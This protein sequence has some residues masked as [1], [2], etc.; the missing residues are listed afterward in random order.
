MAASPLKIRWTAMAARDLKSVHE[1]VSEESPTQADALIDR[2]LSSIEVLER[3]PDLGRKGRV[4][5]TREL[6]IARTPFIVFYRL[7]RD[8][9]EI[10]SVLHAARK[11]PDNL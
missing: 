1:Y 2:I 7:R 3:F 4:Q 8:Q 5:G 6:V 10:L 9:I 11:W